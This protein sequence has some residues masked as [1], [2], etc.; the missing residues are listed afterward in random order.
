MVL[1]CILAATPVAA[2]ETGVVSGTVILKE[3]GGLVDGAVILIVGTGGFALTD[4]GT[5]EIANVPVG[6]YTIVAERERLSAGHQM[7][8]VTAGGTAIADFELSLSPVRE[9]VTVTAAAVGAEATLQAFNT[10][11]TVD[12]FEIAQKSAGSLGEALEHE[13]GIANRSFGPGASRPII[14]GFGGDRVAIAY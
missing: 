12:S 2:Q 1:A 13:P 5:Y 6:T 11:T 7:V 9:E 3:N 4:D 10:V 14:R 8:T